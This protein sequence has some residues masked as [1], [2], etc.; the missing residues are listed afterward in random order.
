[1]R[2]KHMRHLP[3]SISAGNIVGIS[4]D[5]RRFG[6]WAALLALLLALTNGQANQRR[7]SQPYPQIDHAAQAKIALVQ[8]PLMFIQNVGQF[9]A[10]TRYALSNGTTL[11]TLAEDAL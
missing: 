2:G 9:G 11:L 4:H 3:S 6:A 1:M 8:A 7:V 5:H 10:A